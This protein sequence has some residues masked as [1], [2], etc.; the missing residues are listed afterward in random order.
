MKKKKPQTKIITIPVIFTGFISVEV[1]EEIEDKDVQLIAHKKALALITATTENAT[2]PELEAFENMAD[3][4][5]LPLDIFE[6]TWDETK[7]VDVHGQWE[8]NPNP[9]EDYFKDVNDDFIDIDD[10]KIKED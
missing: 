7:I 9:D 10:N 2:A 8:K 1:P 5:E 6:K 4:T 3:E